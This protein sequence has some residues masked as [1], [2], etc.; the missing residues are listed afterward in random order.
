MVKRV[1]VVVVTVIAVALAAVGIGVGVN[2]AGAQ[3]DS[4]TSTVTCPLGGH[5]LGLGG[6]RGDILSS[7]QVI[8][9]Q[10]LGMTLSELR[11]ELQADKSIATIAE[12]QGVELST[13][14]DALIAP[15]SANLALLVDAGVVTQEESDACVAEMTEKLT[16]QLNATPGE[17][18]EGDNFGPGGRGERGARGP[19]GFG[20]D[21]R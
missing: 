3:D 6:G 14:V 17:R 18:P 1:A 21:L 16:E 10:T 20:F 9:A 13:I 2:V 4:G 11:T 7:P 5:G 12:E 19:R 15:R 8:L